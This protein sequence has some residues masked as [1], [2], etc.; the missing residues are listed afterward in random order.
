MGFLRFLGWVFIPYVMIFVR[1][2]K[3]GGVGKTFGL[4]WA[5]ICGLA[6][7]GNMNKDETVKEASA[8]VAAAVAVEQ[9]AGSTT[10]DKEAKAKADADAKAQKEAD[11]KA[12][13]EAD[14]KAKA[15]AEA[16]AKADV[17][18]KAPHL[19]ESSAVGNLAVGIG[20]EVKT[21]QSVGN[22]FLNQKAQG[23]YWVFS[24]GIKNG[25]KEARMID[26]SM[27]Q[28]VSSDG[29]KYEPDPTAS[30]Y[31][32]EA[33]KFFLQSINPGIQSNGFI[34]FDMPSDAK[35]KMADFKLKVSSGVGFKA[36]TSTDFI[37]K[38]R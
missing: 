9:K 8:P 27:F 3:L 17:E 37:L 20:K 1:W 21:T 25:D 29:I 24:V 14:D 22:Q 18:E 38:A 33:G 15:E 32:N 11:A 19:G 35:D 23:T 30:M 36:G 10:E 4:I 7:I 31:A 16:K 12:K 28:L 6:V 34:V 2:G 26:T 5:V 13:K